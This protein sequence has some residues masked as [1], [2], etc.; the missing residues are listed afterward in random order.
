[1]LTVVYGENQKMDSV[2]L[3]TKRCGIEGYVDSCLKGSTKELQAIY[4]DNLELLKEF[5][6]LPHEENAGSVVW[7]LNDFQIKLQYGERNLELKK[8][9]VAII[10][11]DMTLAS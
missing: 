11:K 5:Y 8:W 2:I 7:E 4:N 9:D 10:F 1:M 6:G 3:E